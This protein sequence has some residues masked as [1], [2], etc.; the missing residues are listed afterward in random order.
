MA[1]SLDYLF[2]GKGSDIASLSCFIQLTTICHHIRAL[3]VKLYD[4]DLLTDDSLESILYLIT[5]SKAAV[6]HLTSL[7]DY[8]NF[9]S[10]NKWWREDV[11]P[12]EPTSNQDFY[13]IKA[14]SSFK[15]TKGF[16]TNQH[17]LSLSLLQSKPARFYS[18]LSSLQ[19]NHSKYPE[20][21]YL[22]H[23]IAWLR[24][25]IE[26]KIINSESQFSYLFR[27]RQRFSFLA[28]T[29]FRRLRSSFYCILSPLLNR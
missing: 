17:S 21:I 8:Q 7:K 18:E 6:S 29:L 24:Y 28:L 23:V 5:E 2:L 26:K 14:G 22:I 27:L 4:L 16:D 10:S 11:L 12:Y 15:K 9:D 19:L 20:I 13:G 25:R 1:Q 3:Y